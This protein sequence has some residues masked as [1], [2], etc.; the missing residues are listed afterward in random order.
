M[1]SFTRLREES[2]R[3]GID[4]LLT[5]LDTAF[6]FLDVAKTT[7]SPETRVRNRSNAHEAYVIA[8][9]MQTRVVMEPRQKAMF[10][11]KLE[12]LKETLQDLGF[13]V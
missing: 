1:S 5:E 8:Q 4:F 7:G 2:N 11:E 3:I 13:E 12:L 10:D 6:T 9:R